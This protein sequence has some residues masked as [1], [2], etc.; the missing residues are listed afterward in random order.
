MP[1][2][3]RVRIGVGPQ[4]RER[5]PKKKKEKKEKRKRNK[6]HV[7]DVTR[8]SGAILF[9]EQH[10]TRGG[11]TSHRNGPQWVLCHFFFF[12]IPA[13]LDP[14]FLFHFFLAPHGIFSRVGGVAP[15]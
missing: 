2:G 15:S 9:L 1:A 5:E 4:L 14:S 12:P 13:I 6:T 10:W 8:V 3:A 7:C 11:I